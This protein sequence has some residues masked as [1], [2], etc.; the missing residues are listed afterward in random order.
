MEIV[1]VILAT[2]IVGGLIWLYI[3]WD[4]KRTI[5][6][7]AQI[8]QR[9]EEL[10]AEM[11]RSW[12]K[13]QSELRQTIKPKTVVPNIPVQKHKP[14]APVH[15]DS[16]HHHHHFH[17]DT[18]SPLTGVLGVAVVA[19]LV[20]DI[21]EDRV[22]QAVAEAFEHADGSF[23]GGGASASWSEPVRES[24]TPSSRSDY[25]S[26]SNYDSG[27]DSSSSSPSSD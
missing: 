27:S 9:E 5:K 14:A 7:R 26:G 6:H 1:V 22:E 4:T 20:E 3:H 10:R 19:D 24:Y 13:N 2:I 21:L 12:N 17:H 16:S 8:R 15:H 11:M 23:G 18:S 25:D